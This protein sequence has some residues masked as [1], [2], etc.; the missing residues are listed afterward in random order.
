MP[1]MTWTILLLSAVSLAAGGAEPELV[2]AYKAQS[3]LYA[4]PLVADVAPTPGQET[5]L[6][7]S[8]ARRLCCVDAQGNLLWE[9]DGQWSKRLTSAAALSFTAR[10]GKGTLAVGNSDGWLACVDA[11]SGAE[12]WRKKIGGIEW[13]GVLWADLDGDGRDELVA[14]TERRGIIALDAQG[15]SLWRYAGSEDDGALHITAPMAA[16]DV[17]R[18]GKSEVFAASMTGPLCVN[19]GGTLRWRV[20][21]GDSFKSSVVIADTDGDGAPELYCQSLDDNAVYRFDA[22]TGAQVWRVVMVGAADVYPS[23]CISVGDLDQDGI[24]EIVVADSL[25]YVYCLTCDG[26]TRWVFPIGKRTHAAPS[27]GDVDGDGMVEVLVAGGDH[28]LYCLDAAGSLEWRFKA[29]LRLMYAATMAD[30]DGDGKT[31]ILFG[32]SDKTLRCLTLG[33]RYDPAL[34]PWP[35]RRYNAA[36]SGASFGSAAAAPNRTIAERLSL[37][38]H[39]GFEDGK[40]VSGEQERIPLYAARRKLPRGWTSTGA[41]DGQWVLDSEVKCE[42]ASSLRVSGATGGFAV[43]TAPIEVASELRLVDAAIACRGSEPGMSLLRWQGLTGVLREDVLEAAAPDDGGWAHHALSGVRPPFGARWVQLL[44]V[45]GGEEPVWWD[46][47]QLV[48]VFARRRQLKPLVNQVGYDAGAPKRFTAQ[49]NFRAEIATFEIVDE[50]GNGVFTAPLAHAGRI[51]GAYGND[52]GYEYWR[53]DFSAWDTP[54]RYRVRIILGGR[55]ALSWPFEIGE[56]LLWAR[57][58]RDAYRFFY[59]QRCG[60]AIPGFHDACHLDDARSLDGERQYELWGGWHDAGDYNTYHNAPYVQG[61]AR[62]YSIGKA[63]FDV[64]DEDGNGRSDFLDEILWGGEHSRRMI[65]PDGSAFGGITS[66]Y[67]FWGAPELETDNVPGTGDERPFDGPEDMGRDSSQHLAAMAR[68]ARFV[69]DK[70]PWVAAA[71]R[72]MGWALANDRRGPF[73]F[74]AAVDLFA[75]TGDRKYAALA[76]DLFPGPN[77]DVADSVRLYDAL[78]GEDH[79]AGLRDALVAKADGILARSANPFGIMPMGGTAERPNFFG[80]PEAQGGWHVGTSRDL[81]YAANTVAM[82]YQYEPNPKYLEFIYDQ[83]NWELG[84][85]PFDLSLMEGCGSVFLPTYHHRY[86]FAGVPRGA[87]PGSVVNGVTWR[88]VKDDRP[89]LDLRGLDIPAFEPN[90]VWL[91]HNT[92]YLNALANLRRAREGAASTR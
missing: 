88:A 84:N 46:D 62:A 31:D 28:Y 92:A 22:E 23:S 45:A 36:Q 66:G 27:L 17:D 74:S 60:M 20:R 32:G 33:G 16:A 56:N 26:E 80:T 65:A 68:I 21:S 18:D 91:P 67:G 69:D 30:V 51:T 15:E 89:F 29:G 34:M 90:E 63:A 81:L 58:S 72:A 6:S 71:D 1:R 35:S 82:A 52:W 42:G 70:A 75:A 14:G 50:D 13:G 39:G 10:P 79:A 7:D 5:I 59:Y 25:G 85:N 73:Q 4:P 12:L 64:Q 9:Y 48:G 61:L 83:F 24:A 8:E 41:G 53:G 77:P 43:A 40:V 2:W 44:C 37:F 57:T 11:E 76:K 86:T 55:T 49:S 78:F 87:V 38:A 54:G 19:S 3:N 47:A